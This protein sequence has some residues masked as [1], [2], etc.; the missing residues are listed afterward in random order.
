MSIPLMSL[1]W[2]STMLDPTEVSVLGCLASHAN[3]YGESCFAG[4]PRIAGLTR[5]SVRQL[6]RVLQKLEVAGWL[7]VA[8]GRTLSFSL[9]KGGNMLPPYSPRKGDKVTSL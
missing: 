9:E 7:Q 8:R 3:D 6:R 1:V 4:M 5:L 2:T